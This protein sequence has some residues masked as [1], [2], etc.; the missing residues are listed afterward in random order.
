MCLFVIRYCN[1][2]G[3]SVIVDSSNVLIAF[4]F[5][6]A[7]SLGAGFILLLSTGNH[8]IALSIIVHSYASL[9]MISGL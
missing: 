7:G 3:P 5:N 6:A 2:D 1:D 8:D 9:C 4:T